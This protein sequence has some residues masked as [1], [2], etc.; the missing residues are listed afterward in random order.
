[1]T[2]FGRPSR[3]CDEVPRP[4]RGACGSPGRHAPVSRLPGGVVARSRGAGSGRD[5]VRQGPRLRTQGEGRS[6]RSAP[7]RRGLGLRVNG[8]APGQRVERSRRGTPGIRGR[9]QPPAAG[10]AR[11]LRRLPGAA[12]DGRSSG[13][14]AGLSDCGRL[15]V[16]GDASGGQRAGIK[17]SPLAAARAA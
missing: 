17:G 1:M 3:D 16:D 11:G 2:A 15:R 5:P 7:R 6:S 4:G 13:A 9:D 8:A 12:G 14:V 10:G